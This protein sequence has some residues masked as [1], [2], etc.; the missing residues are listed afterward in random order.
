[1]ISSHT[2][3][4]THALT[5]RP[6]MGQTKKQKKTMILTS[7]LP[8]QYLPVVVWMEKHDGPDNVSIIYCVVATEQHTQLPPKW[9]K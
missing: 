5:H 8:D 3:T 9:E 7:A 6:H 2:H 4:N 1:M